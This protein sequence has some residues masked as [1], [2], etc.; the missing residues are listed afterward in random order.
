[1]RVRIAAESPHPLW[2][3][4]DMSLTADFYYRCLIPARVLGGI[5]DF[6]VS[7]ISRD[8]D[9]FAR[10]VARNSDDEVTLFAIGRPT[11]FKFLGMRVPSMVPVMEAINDAGGE[12]WL[13]IDDDYSSLPPSAELAARWPADAR[14]RLVGGET[15][16]AIDAWRERCAAD[17]ARALA[18]ARAVIVS[19]E[20][21]AEVVRARNPHVL[22]V[23]NM[24]DPG[25]FSPPFRSEGGPLRLGY[26]GSALHGGRDLELA[27][28]G[29]LA[30]GRLPGVELHFWGVHPRLSESRESGGYTCDG[31]PYQFHGGIPFL[32]DYVRE[33]GILDVA[34]A[35]QVDTP[36]NRARSHCKW[37]EHAFHGT[38]MVVSDMPSY[39]CVEDGVTGLVARDATAFATCVEALLTDAELRR[40]IGEGARRDLLLHHTPE[41]HGPALRQ[42]F[43]RMLQTA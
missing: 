20:Y 9:T 27:L 28:P 29:L 30:A 18:V 5:A 7:V 23:P 6:R 36:G 42:A 12:T 16:E 1:M 8:V 24:L 25:H 26:G 3:Q 33:I 32:T 34:V 10:A 37:L 19:T 14:E 21:L 41:A 15:L 22:V 38:A 31:V 17:F 4:P 13:E 11:V 2:I 43:A 35:P 39:H 40:R